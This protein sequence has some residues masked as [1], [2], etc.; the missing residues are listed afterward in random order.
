MAGS[1]H[2][3][4][5]ASSPTAPAM[6]GVGLHPSLRR[7]SPMP[8]LPRPPT[9]FTS[10]P[11]PQRQGREDR[12]SGE[13]QM[14]SLVTPSNPSIVYPRVPAPSTH[15]LA[16]PW[17]AW[18]WGSGF[19]TP[20]CSPREGP[21]HSL[22][23]LTHLPPYPCPCSHPLEDP[24]DTQLYLT[25]FQSGDGKTGWLSRPPLEASPPSLCRRVRLHGHPHHPG[26]C[27]RA[28]GQRAEW[29]QGAAAGREQVGWAGAGVGVWMEGRRW[30]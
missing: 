15:Y 1:H 21:Q 17:L 12:T 5:T 25:S 27:A 9:P 2:P 30:G 16:C 14:F 19:L 8:A 28:P 23:Y 10:P 6:C 4:V 18:P 22:V 11:P 13:I 20:R 26:G 24:P 3:C 7:V 29:G